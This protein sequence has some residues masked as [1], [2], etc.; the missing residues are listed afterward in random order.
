MSH[1]QT[2]PTARPDPVQ[3]GTLAFR[4]A[5]VDYRWANVFDHAR[6]RGDWQ[7]LETEVRQA[8]ACLRLV[9]EEGPPLARAAERSTERTFRRARLL[10]AAEDLEAWL[11]ERGLTVGQ[12]RRYIRGEVLRRRHAPE[13]HTV[14][15]RYP[16]GDAEVDAALPVWGVC[17]GAFPRWAEELATRAAAA[18]A[19][20]TD[21]DGTDCPPRPDDLDAHEVLFD[22]FATETATSR[23]LEALVATRY[24]DWLR[25]DCDIAVFA[26]TDT[27][28]EARLCVRDDG[29]S[30]DEA[31]RAGG[32]VRQRR[33]LL[34]E[35]IDADARHHFVR[36]RDG[37]LL[38]P[39][40]LDGEPALVRVHHKNAPSLDDDELR[41]R[42]AH[43]L[44]ATAAAR[45]VDDRVERHYLS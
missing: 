40:L 8:L 45:E 2:E 31:A 36:A 10:L 43:Q 34:V 3:R 6:R 38:G 1:P 32:A 41:A 42:A 22:R 30:L 29:W 9:A 11:S 20:C 24:L 16:P 18:H 33:S 44:V 27:A 17:S 28:K 21:R 15:T 35:E 13:L 23:R 4:I 26:D 19:T 5:G 39:L 14:T 12:W 25:V 7:I 37:D